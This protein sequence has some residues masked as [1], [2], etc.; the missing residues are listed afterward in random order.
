M[1]GFA[2]GEEKNAGSTVPESP[3]IGQQQVALVDHA[4]HL[5]Q[6]ARASVDLDRERGADAE[7]VVVGGDGADGDLGGAGRPAT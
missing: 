6:P 2:S 7:A 1:G 3:R 5:Q 4:G